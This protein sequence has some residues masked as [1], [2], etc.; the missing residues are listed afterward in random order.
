M[1][2]HRA[3]SDAWP[4]SWLIADWPAPTNVRAV[5]TSREG[6]VSTAPFDAL[7]LGLHVG[8][9]ESDVLQNRQR[10]ALWLGTRPVFMEQVHG[11]CL[12]DLGRTTLEKAGV[13]Q[14]D[15]AVSRQVGQA[16]TIMVADCLPV[17]MCS[18]DGQTVAAAHAGW[19]G[20]L[21]R[22]GF[23]VLESM[24]QG[25]RQS[26]PGQDQWLVWLGPC[27]G[28]EA[29][30]VGDDVRDAFIGQC[31][32]ASDHFQP[33]SRGKW[34]ADLPSLARD[35]LMSMGLTALYGNDGSRAWCTVHNP[36][37]FFSHRRDRVSGRL[38]AAIW[39]VA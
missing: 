36:S 35:R 27:I 25:V 33:L 24:V 3:D 18:A 31:K 29:F 30:E 12:L 22:Q 34:L 5:C 37:R 28:P 21:G 19:R 23:G 32:T 17:L 1:V 8:D 20:L 16:C 15:A 38:A 2:M 11:S 7:N 9:R 6:G 4:E 10:L 14:A 26:S 13:P 39:R